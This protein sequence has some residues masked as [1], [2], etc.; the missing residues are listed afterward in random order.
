MQ[1][2]LGTLIPCL[3]LLILLWVRTPYHRPTR[4]EFKNSLGMVI[5]GNATD[6]D[7]RV[8]TI[9]PLR[10]D[11]V[12][13]EYRQRLVDIEEAYYTGG[14]PYLFSKKGLAALTEVYDDLCKES[15]AS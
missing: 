6:N 5:T 11:P 7:W 8:L 2:F 4:E 14:S 9:I 10:Y 12:L 1:I 3:V 13:E 15:S